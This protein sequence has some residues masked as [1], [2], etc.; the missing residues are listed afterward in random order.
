M[1]TVVIYLSIKSPMKNLQN[2]PS[3]IFEA[4]KC[5]AA[6]WYINWNAHQKNKVDVQCKY[7]VQVAG[8]KNK[9]QEQKLT[10]PQC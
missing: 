10:L 7:P 5:D 3:F 4:Q 8:E 1:Q 6:I 2:L 9:Y